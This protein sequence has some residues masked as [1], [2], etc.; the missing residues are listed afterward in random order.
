MGLLYA[1]TIKFKNWLGLDII[2]K[3]LGKVNIISGHK[4]A[5]KTA[6]I[7]GLEYSLLGKL[8]G[9]E[10]RT[11][12]VK[13]GEK[14]ATLFVEL[15]D[16]LTHEEMMI[17]RK[18][19]TESSDYFKV[20]KPGKAVPQTEGF[21]R[22][23]IKGEI[24]RPGE[25]LRKKPEEQS[26]I[27]LSLLEI[28]W[29]MENIKEWFGEVPEVNYTIHI[30]KILK[31]IEEKYYEER[32]PINRAI[33]VLKAQAEGYRKQ[34][35]PNYD[36]EFW[37]AKKVQEYYDKVAEANEINRKITAARNAI[38]GLESTIAAIS[39][40]AE[41]DKQTKKNAFDR[42]RS[43]GR[44]FIQFLNQK[45]EKLQTVIDG[46]RDKYHAEVKNIDEAVKNKVAEAELKYC[47]ALQ[48]LKNEHE[49]ILKTIAEDAEKSKN[50]KKDEIAA[51]VETAKEDLSKNKQSVAAKEQ[52][53]LHIDELEKQSL[54][55]IDEK[56]KEQIK[57][58]DAEAGN[59]KKTLENAK[60]IEGI[61]LDE[62]G[63]VVEIDT[64]PLTDA[65]NEVAQM[66]SFLRDYDLMKSI[67]IDKIAPKQAQSDDL[68]TKIE[69]ARSLPLELLKI[70]KCPIAG[71]TVDDKGML[72]VNG[73]LLDG[74]SDGEKMQDISV[75][76]AKA[77]ADRADVKFIC[78]DGFQNLN[79]IEQRKMIQEA[80]T[81]GYQWFF[82][83]TDDGELRIEII[84]DVEWPVSGEAEQMS[85]I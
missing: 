84:D 17:D 67:L 77:L 50:T 25:F 61:T 71:I 42:T 7:E 46:A 76:I 39:A 65:A 68:T 83:I 79:P 3:Q 20:T 47:A 31:L 11:E 38:Q 36:G 19:R 57:T 37:R 82:L 70:S 27:I 14:E 32:T 1:T 54:Q 43:E 26:A 48:T 10:R 6:T 69:K 18:V 62:N 59:S 28:P 60:S 22:S 80:K 45:I 23:L 24:F 35:P 74:L 81:D 9:K 53:L 85:L 52:E 16:Q 75:K 15:E 21:L 41:I 29:T 51:E 44:E 40:N 56:T 2:D 8:D 73:T 72:R 66:Q 5:G 58:A 34:L 63:N 13:H 78:F 49:N 30:L 55:A 64:K 33:E 4:G 12:L